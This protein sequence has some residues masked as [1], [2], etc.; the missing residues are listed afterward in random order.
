MKLIPTS[1][2]LT[3]KI[4]IFIILLVCLFE[5][6]KAQD[7]FAGTSFYYGNSNWVRTDNGSYYNYENVEYGANVFWQ[8]QILKKDKSVSAFSWKAKLNLVSSHYTFLYSNTKEKNFRWEFLLGSKAHFLTTKKLKP[9][10]ELLI[11]IMTQQGYE[12]RL[13]AGF[14]FTEELNFG[15]DYYLTS[16]AFFSFD[17]GWKHISNLNF[18]KLNKGLDVIIFQVGYGFNI[19]DKMKLTF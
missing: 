6:G 2:N 8:R 18:Y 14:S 4:L 15:V 9:H 3:Y 17:F 7:K 13:H 16:K 11:G 12:E 5:W 1:E 10:V 19:S